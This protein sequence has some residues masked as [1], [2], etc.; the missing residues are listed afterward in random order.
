[1]KRFFKNILLNT[2]PSPIVEG[3]FA[4]SYDD[5]AIISLI[6]KRYQKKWLSGP[7]PITHPELYNPC[8]PPKGW[9]YDAFYEV[10]FEVDII[11]KD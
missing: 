1:M 9:K 10:W 4:D 7:T 6:K 5:P 3:K 2:N 11:G 8:D